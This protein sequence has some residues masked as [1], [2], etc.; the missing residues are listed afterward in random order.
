[1]NL[2]TLKRLLSNFNKITNGNCRNFIS[3][4]NGK[5][6]TIGTNDFDKYQLIH[7]TKE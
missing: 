5:E 4:D 1:M 3:L 6:I 7:V 2:Q